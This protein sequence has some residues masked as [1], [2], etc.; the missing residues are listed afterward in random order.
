MSRPDQS[1]SSF[2]SEAILAEIPVRTQLALG[3]E[4][5]RLFLTNHRLIL[6]HMGKRGAGALATTS[7]FGRL[8]GALEDLFKGGQ[9]SL[10]KRNIGGLSP[11][12]ILNADKDN[13]FLGY[14]EIVEVGL[15]DLPGR[16]GIQILTE[17]DKL[18][19]FTLMSF[20]SAF[21]ILHESLGDKVVVR[22]AS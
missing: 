10:R 15:A 18:Q 3:T 21:A 12:E 22:R 7:L 1:G 14:N 5:L 4:R 11:Q 20:E 13:F 6:A 9:E 8:S 19:L 2:P 16:V 17:N